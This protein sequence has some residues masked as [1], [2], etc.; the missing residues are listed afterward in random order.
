MHVQ[1]YFYVHECRHVFVACVYV[2]L[3]PERIQRLCLFLKQESQRKLDVS[4]GSSVAGLP[5]HVYVQSSNVWKLYSYCVL[6][7]LSAESFLLLS[8]VQWLGLTV[9]ALNSV[10][11]W[12]GDGWGTAVFSPSYHWWWNE[13]TSFTVSKLGFTL[14]RWGSE[15][16][17]FSY[18]QQCF[19]CSSPI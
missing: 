17:K 6:T 7:T 12:I 14:F 4:Q 3:H 5:C 18:R 8:Q 19:L 1:L 9:L 15:L 16:F 2:C 13:N 11:F 10:Q